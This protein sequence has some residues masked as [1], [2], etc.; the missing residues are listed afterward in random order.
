MGKSS[1]GW[2]CSSSCCSCCGSST[3]PNSRARNRRARGGPTPAA[4]AMV[5]CVDCGVYLPSA[6]AKPGPRGPLCGDPQVPAQ[7]DKARQTTGTR[8]T[9]GKRRGRCSPVQSASV[10]STPP[11]H[12]PAAAACSPSA[13]RCWHNAR[14]H[15]RR[16]RRAPLR[17]AAPSAARQLI[18]SLRRSAHGPIDCRPAARHSSVRSAAAA[19]VDHRFDAAHPVDRRPVPRG[20]RRAAARSRAAA[21][22]ARR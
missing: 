16:S 7:R 4:G 14:C 6:D 17:R 9:R 1:S 13:S 18:P 11:R 21:R 2:S 15:E 10:V 19:G 8:A 5:R 3:S 20:L 12:R 22:P